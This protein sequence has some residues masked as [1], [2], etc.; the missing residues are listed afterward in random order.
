MQDYS[1]VFMASQSITKETAARRLVA[2][3]VKAILWDHDPI[4]VHVMVLACHALLREYGDAKGLKS[5]LDW[6]NY[7]RPEY[8]QEAFRDYIKR[9]YNFLKHAQ[10]DPDEILDI[11]NLPTQNDMMLLFNCI[12]HIEF[13][14]KS[15]PH[16]NLHL[17][18]IQ[19]EHPNFLKD[20]NYKDIILSLANEMSE[21]ETRESRLKFWRVYYRVNKFEVHENA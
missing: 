7:I 6:R 3:S 9:P 16:A 2:S 21:Y 1:G 8:R 14:G 4:G 18:R 19:I 10:R 12:A 15:F 20:G 17:S 13:F 11:G 5:K